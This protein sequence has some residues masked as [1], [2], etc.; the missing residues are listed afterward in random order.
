MSRLGN[1][2]LS[3]ANRKT[4]PGALKRE[5]RGDLDWIT[6]K[7][8][9]KDRG[10]RYGSASELAE[11]VRR[12]LADLPVSAGPPGAR[13]R[14]RKFVRRH[15]AAVIAATVV[16]VGLPLLIGLF[17]WQQRE[18]A[19]EEGRLRQ[20]ARQQLYVAD[21]RLASQAFH[22]GRIDRLEELLDRHR[23][24]PGEEDLRRFEWFHWWRA[25]RLHLAKLSDPARPRWEGLVA[26]PDGRL[27][28]VSALGEVVLY[29]AES[30]RVVGTLAKSR[31]IDPFE[32]TAIAF[33]PD[34]QLLAMD[35]GTAIQLWS[36]RS[37]TASGVGERSAASRLAHPSDD[38]REARVLRIAFSPTEPILATGDELGRLELWNHETGILLRT[39]EVGGRLQG[40]A[41]SSDGRSLLA[42]AQP[43]SNSD[44]LFVCD[45]RSG[46]ILR[47]VSASGRGVG[48][49]AY[50]PHSQ[51]IAT[52]SREA[53]IRL[54]DGRLQPF[55][56]IPT[57]GIP[58]ALSFSA[59]GRRLVAGTMGTNSVLVWE[60]ESEPVRIATLEGHSGQVSGVAFAGSG[61][62]IWSASVDSSVRV[63]DLTLAQQFKTFRD[64]VLEGRDVLAWPLGVTPFSRQALAY[65]ADGRRVI[66]A[67]QGGDLRSWSI[68]GDRWQPDPKDRAEYR[69]VAASNDGAVWAGITNDGQLRVWDIGGV[70]PRSEQPLLE[71]AELLA[72]TRA[73]TRVGLAVPGLEGVLIRDLIT[74]RSL[75]IPTQSSSVR[76]Q[77][78]ADGRLLLL[79]LDSSNE[80][81]DASTDPPRRLWHESAGGE[82]DG[83]R[84]ALLGRD[85]SCAFSADGGGVAIGGTTDEI[86]LLDAETGQ[87]E[88][89]L[90]GNT[91]WVRSLAFSPDGRSLVSGAYDGPVRI[92][93][94]YSGDQRS[95]LGS[96]IG[97][98]EAIAF[99]P[100]GDSVASVSTD[101]ELRIWLAATKQ[102]SDRFRADGENDRPAH[103]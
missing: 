99:S 48:A 35:D 75:K 39:V 47:A 92:W 29:D 93:D 45:P 22:E 1:L 87:M 32:A 86:R 78:S 20:V 70:E 82:A 4:A 37:L 69:S 66:Y 34:G 12:Y 60:L 6:M 85:M 42:G 52:A 16:V 40:L 91:A 101:G 50:S 67:G 65:S 33:S 27:V 7:A 73:G 94:T 95:L 61:D 88:R 30:Y 43:G 72:V 84:I 71:A 17:A 21:M 38:G 15:R 11:D 36:R 14:A 54:W 26:S 5:L 25:A 57:A 103:R 24:Q 55:A 9:E 68:E 63:W 81:W 62:T 96:H 3:A 8:L 58:S 18:R 44:S 90:R 2:A 23:A 102:E 79:L 19:R 98:V 77:F 53:T 64:P 13:Y 49:F 31:G 89:V 10:R 97:S 56:S 41:F 80:M 51:V 59:D 100:T 46:K 83:R 28:A 76:P 74:G